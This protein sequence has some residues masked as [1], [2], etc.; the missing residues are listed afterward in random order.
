MHDDTEEKY[1]SDIGT[2]CGVFNRPF[3]KAILR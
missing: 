2:L 1:L 3:F